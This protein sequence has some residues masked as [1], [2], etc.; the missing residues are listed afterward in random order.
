MPEQTKEPLQN[1]D[2][3]NLKDKDVLLKILIEALRVGKRIEVLEYQ[4]KYFEML[5]ARK[6]GFNLTDLE[7]SVFEYVENLKK[8]LEEEKEFLKHV[9]SQHCSNKDADQ[10]VGEVSKADFSWS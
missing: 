3:E 6:Y 8:E 7:F 2:T 10:S 1:P 5:Y 4:I 9:V